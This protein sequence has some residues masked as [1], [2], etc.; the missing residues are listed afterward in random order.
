MLRRDHAEGTHFYTTA[1]FECVGCH[2]EKPDAP[3]HTL[4]FGD[5]CP[6][7]YLCDA[8][9]EVAKLSS[10]FDSADAMALYSLDSGAEDDWAHSEGWGYLARMGKWIVSEDTQGFVYARDCDTPERADRE[11]QILYDEGYGAD[12]D[13]AYIAYDSGRWHVT[14]EGR[15]L[16]VWPTQRSRHDYDEGITERRAIA[17][18]RL[19]AM[20]TGFYPN[21]WLVND[22]GDMR[23]V[24]Y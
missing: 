16:N 7:V 3:G 22:R 20:R 24:S 17:R 14:F 2:T 23:R 19:E 12:E 21:A 1:R 11:F 10:K 4:D 8:C 15:D 6:P 13:D 18:V 5:G 9:C